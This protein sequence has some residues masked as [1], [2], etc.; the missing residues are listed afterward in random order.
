M[1]TPIDARQ[2]APATQ[3]NREPI[4]E[5]LL[6]ILPAKGNILEVASGTGEHGIF[7]ASHLYPRQWIPSDPNPMLRES[8]NAWRDRTPVDNLQPPLAINA[9]DSVWSIEA[10]NIEIAAIVNINMIHI[11]PWSACLGLMAGANRLLSAGGILYLYGP[12][13]QNGKH[14]AP[15][16][17]TFDESLRAQ[18]SQWGVRNL[19][20]VIEVAKANNLSLLEIIP[21]PANN[22]S[23]VWQRI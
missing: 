15:S 2:Y 8:I 11:A 1:N 6:Q 22:L 13:K 19:E 12:F 14:T 18:N 7:F 16:N 17:V 10:K 9:E 3:R 4:L 21:M 5:V 20:D 23:V